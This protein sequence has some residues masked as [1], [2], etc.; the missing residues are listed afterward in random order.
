LTP[1]Q[2]IENQ[3]AFISVRLEI[4]SKNL[5]ILQSIFT[6]TCEKYSEC[7]VQFPPCDIHY[8]NN[9]L[10]IDMKTK[11]QT[12]SLDAHDFPSILPS[13]ILS[14]NKR[15]IPLHSR[16]NINIQEDHCQTIFPNDFDLSLHRFVEFSDNVQI[17][18]VISE[19]RSLFIKDIIE[20][21]SN[22]TNSEDQIITKQFLN[23]RSPLQVV[24]RY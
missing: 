18:N 10:S 20:F 11:A 22:W 15:R 4:Y 8:E 13:M 24:K 9:I 12:I 2:L 21:S 7:F 1:D 17:N 5:I 3:F 19:N 6:L 14:M 16:N 23:Q